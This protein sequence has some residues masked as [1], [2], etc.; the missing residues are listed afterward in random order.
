METLGVILW[1]ADKLETI[2]ASWLKGSYSF[3]NT[4]KSQVCQATAEKTN[5]EVE[6]VYEP[7]TYPGSSGRAKT[8]GTPKRTKK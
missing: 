7:W 1:R 8:K 2:T 4:L 3:Y 5:G 6:R